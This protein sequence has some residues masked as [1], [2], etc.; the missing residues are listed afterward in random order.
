MQSKK[1]SKMDFSNNPVNQ[2]E[3][4]E[5]I[6]NFREIVEIIAERL[7]DSEV[8]MLKIGRKITLSKKTDTLDE[9]LGN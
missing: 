6:K 9:Q 1:E 2:E 4:E 3:T 5:V 7:E 8:T